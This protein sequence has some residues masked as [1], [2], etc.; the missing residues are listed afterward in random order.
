MKV[1]IFGATGSIGKHLV[2][3]SLSLGHV[4]TVFVRNPEKLGDVRHA[5]LNIFR[6]DVFDRAAVEQAIKGHDAVLCALGDGATGRV[7][8]EGTRN[9]VDAME[10]VGVKRLICQ[11]TL[12]AGDSRG[13]LN[14][15][16][17]HI[18]FGI[19]LKKALRDH[20]V[21]EKAVME[22]DL[23]WTVV[24]PAAFTDGG[25]THQYKHGFAPTDRSTTLKISRADVAAFML[26]QLASDQYLRKTP[27][28]AY[29]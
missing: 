24:R 7:R 13:N 11:S 9:I 14:F 19:L 17:K 18:M 21:Q 10:K 20:E 12:G 27:G 26:K 6:G 16:W 5:N 25:I 29:A 22:S 8:S 3:Q 15:F 1:I 2:Q 4:T 28:L 23:D